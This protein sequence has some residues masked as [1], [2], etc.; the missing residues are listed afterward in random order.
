M[1]GKP[2]FRITDDS[3]SAV[4]LEVC[5]DA[6]DVAVAKEATDVET[7]PRGPISDQLS[8]LIDFITNVQQKS[9]KFFGEHMA[10]VEDKEVKDDLEDK[11]SD[12]EPDSTLSPKENEIAKRVKNE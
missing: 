12:D 7:F 10:G 9:H 6:H 3:T 2:F 5:P 4:L 1:S 11:E 8:T